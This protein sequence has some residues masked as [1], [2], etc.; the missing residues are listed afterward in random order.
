M[1]ELVC[2]SAYSITDHPDKCVNFHGSLYVVNVKVTDRIDALTGFVVDY[3][4]KNVLLSKKSLMIW[5][6]II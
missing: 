6:I 1:K 5:I 3:G 4:I 2:D